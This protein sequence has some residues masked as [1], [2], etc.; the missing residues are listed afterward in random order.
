MTFGTRGLK[1]AMK[2]ADRSG[3]RFAALIGPAE[4]DAGLVQVKD[5]RNGD[6]EHV[7]ATSAVDWLLGKLS[8]EETE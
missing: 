7:A 2:A 4:R 6:Q 5:L 1:G 3:A 8:G